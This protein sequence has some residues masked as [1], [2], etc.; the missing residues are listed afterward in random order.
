M[1]KDKSHLPSRLY[2]PLIEAARELGCE[3]KDIIHYAAIEALQ[4]S[5]YVDFH[6]TDPAA[7]FHVGIPESKVNDIDEFSMLSGDGWSIDKVEFKNKSEGFYIDGYYAK[8]IQGFF[9]VD[10]HSLIRLE[11]DEKEV[12][13]LHG[14][15]TENEFYSDEVI[16]INFGMDNL[17]E[18]NFSNLCVMASSMSLI[19]QDVVNLPTPEIKKEF[20]SPNG[21]KQA[22]MIKALIEIHY[23]VGKSNSARSLLNTERDTGEMLADFD[24]A[25]IRPPVSGKTLASWLK[26][27]E[28]DFVGIS[29]DKTENST[30]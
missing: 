3:V 21:N 2:Y 18:V 1:K 22:K 23:G 19:R 16:Y 11:F 29:T 7:W 15:H 4:L 28:L 8:A 20:S 27:V 10:G 12:V 9:Y 26:G 24:R 17:L 14:V 25:G 6:Y 30:K 13:Y 5:I